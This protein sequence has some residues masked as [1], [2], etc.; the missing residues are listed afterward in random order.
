MTFKIP[1]NETQKD[2][3]N[4]VLDG[5]S[6]TEAALEVGYAHKYGYELIRKYKEYFLDLIEHKLVL[7]GAQAV[8]TLI[9]SLSSEGKNPNEKINLDT[10]K[11]ILDRVGVVKK[12]RLNISIDGGS[13]VV[14]LPSK[15]KNDNEDK[16]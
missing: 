14:L 1:E 2:F 10:A 7:H 4:L 12:D 6:I 5:N 3:F 13:G 16:E 9:K 11:D 15:D 8:N